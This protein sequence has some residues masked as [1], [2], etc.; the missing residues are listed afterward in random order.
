MPVTLKDISKQSGFSVTTVSRALTGYDDVSQRTRNRILKIADEMGYQPNHIARQLQ[1]QRT[2]TLGLI[3]PTPS[4]SNDDDFFSLL[5]KGI[6]YEA[7]RNGF[8]VLT[9]AAQENV[10]ELEAYRRF[11][12]G[13]R[14]D[15]MVV[16]RTQRE[17]ARIQYLKSVNCPFIVHGRLAPDE[18]SDFDYID[19]D[20]QLGIY[21]VTEHLIKLGHRDIAII[22]P[23][24]DL[25]FTPYRLNGYREALQ[26]YNIPFRETYCTHGDLTYESGLS[27]AKTLLDKQPNLSAIIGANDWMALGAMAVAKERGYPVGNGFAIA[28]YDDIPAA[29]HAEPSLTTVRQPIYDIGEQLTHQ[30]LGIIKDDDSTSYFQHLIKPDLLIRSSSGGA[31]D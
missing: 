5:L 15:G 24:P 22:L 14:V 21:L 1:G 19:V 28:G 9:S 16:A 17:D 8:D 31:Q 3:M 30:L 4:H 23:S 26:K 2:L 29:A 27:G 25:A 18:D 20:S 13:N 10:S 7:A 11:V 6:T 12:G